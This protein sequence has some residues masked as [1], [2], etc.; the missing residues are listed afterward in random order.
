[1]TKV[2][3]L[4]RGVVEAN[5]HRRKPRTIVSARVKDSEGSLNDAIE[6]LEKIFVDRIGSL[7]G[8]VSDDQA[9][10]ASEAHM[11]SRLSRSQG[12]HHCARG[13]A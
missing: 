10:V 13:S 12:K 4:V 5:L 8:S 9:V 6:E 11:P 3:Q 7:K 2:Y 1:M